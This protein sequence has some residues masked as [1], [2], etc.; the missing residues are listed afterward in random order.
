MGSKQ[1]QYKMR[2]THVDRHVETVVGIHAKSSDSSFFFA[3]LYSNIMLEVLANNFMEDKNY[4]TK[5]WF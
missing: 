2:T 5:G 4:G 1:G 3:K